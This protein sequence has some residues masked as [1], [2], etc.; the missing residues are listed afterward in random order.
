LVLV[1]DAGV[2][3]VVGL[4]GESPQPNATAAPA[5]PMMV[6][7]SRRPVFFELIATPLRCIEQETHGR[8]MAAA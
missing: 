4:V 2:E 3:E 1:V 5:A 8:T 6:I 7:A